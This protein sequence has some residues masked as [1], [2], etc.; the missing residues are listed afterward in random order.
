MSSDSIP[1][2]QTHTHTH[3]QL[4]NINPSHAF[5]T[6]KNRSCGDHDSDEFADALSFKTTYA[7]SFADARR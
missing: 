5:A 6:G 2:P 1:N 4:S 3:T 7:L